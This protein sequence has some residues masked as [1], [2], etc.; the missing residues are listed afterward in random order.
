MKKNASFFLFIGLSL[1][2]CSI[3]SSAPSTPF[4]EKS[5]ALPVEAR[6][7]ART[8]PLKELC[9]GTKNWRI[10]SIKQAALNEIYERGI[11]TRQCYSLGLEL[12]P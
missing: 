4:Y 8:A 11:D 6:Q 3:F 9:E 1:S 10:D 5:Y 7:W 12:T 2:G